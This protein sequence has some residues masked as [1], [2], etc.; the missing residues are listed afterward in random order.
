MDALDRRHRS[1]GGVDEGL[2]GCRR[3]CEGLI[4]DDVDSAPDSL[5]DELAPSLRRRRD[6]HSVYPGIEQLAE[7]RENRQTRQ[8]L[9]HFPQAQ[10]GSAPQCRCSSHPSAAWM[11]GA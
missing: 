5:E 2:T 10:L 6:G 9:M 1:G 8:V 11:N 7:R 4:G 3:R